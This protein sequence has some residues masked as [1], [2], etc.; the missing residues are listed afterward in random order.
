MTVE[1]LKAMI[2][3]LQVQIAQLYEQ[4]NRAQG[5]SQSWCYNFNKDLR[6]GES[7]SDVRALQTALQKEGFSIQIS[8]NFDE[9]T[10][11]AV[12][13]FQEKYS[14]EILKPFGLSRGTGFV[15]K[16]TRAKLNNLYGCETIKPPL[17]PV[18][19]P[20]YKTE[21]DGVISKILRSDD[22][23][24]TWKA[25]RTRYGVEIVYIADPKNLKNL[26]AIDKG[27]KPTTGNKDIEL[28]KSF[29]GGD[30][31]IDI[32]KGVI[33]KEGA[34]QYVEGT[35]II[36]N[37]ID[38]IWVDLD[39]NHLKVT[40]KG[41]G[42]SFIFE[43]TD[44]GYTW[45]QIKPPLPIKPPFPNQAWIDSL[46]VYSGP[47]GTK[48]E[49]KGRNFV[50]FEGDINAWIENSQGIRGILYSEPG[51]NSTLIKTTLK[52]PLCQVKVP[53]ILVFFVLVGLI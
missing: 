26:Y 50:G 1:Q 9:I 19:K 3:Q 10:A 51:S 22:G 37:S 35:K 11:S 52:S 38:D 32:S 42:E 36:V 39:F 33:R 41:G 28:I 45:K 23:G 14:S 6:I 12:V 40:V 31:W 24:K 49:I 15:G 25:I 5:Q 20:V 43:S 47:V 13:G 27:G 44:G 34:N 21:F 18:Y 16:S 7:G 29:D 48:L 30:S 4:L 2:Q 17:Q 8:G 53:P 46:S